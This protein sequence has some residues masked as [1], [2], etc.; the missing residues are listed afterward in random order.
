MTGFTWIW[1]QTCFI[2]KNILKCQVNQQSKVGK[3]SSPN[4]VEIVNKKEIA[5]WN[6]QGFLESLHGCASVLWNNGTLI[7]GSLITIWRRKK[8]LKIQ[9]TQGSLRCCLFAI[10]YGL[11]ST[12]QCNFFIPSSIELL[13]LMHSNFDSWLN[14]RKSHCALK[15]QLLWNCFLYK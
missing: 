5:D 9:N 3:D 4:N 12:L 13:S 15:F 6:C 2:L 7:S 14:V 11:I 1:L 8:K 10:K